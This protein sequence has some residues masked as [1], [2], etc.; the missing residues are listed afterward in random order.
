MFR[1]LILMRRT[2]ALKLSLYN[3]FSYVAAEVLSHPLSSPYVL[4][5]EE[6]RIFLL[7][8]L[9]FHYSLAWA[10]HESTDYASQ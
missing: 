10:I 1:F 7:F 6:E 8:S 4:T 9:T 5:I 2:A 3:L